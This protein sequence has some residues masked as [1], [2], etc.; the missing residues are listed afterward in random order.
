MLAFPQSDRYR[1]FQ[2]FASREVM[3]AAEQWDREQK[4]PSAVIAA[5]ADRGYLGCCVPGEYGGQGLDTVTFGALNEAIGRGSSA[6]TGVLTV[7]A[8]VSMTLLKWGTAEQKRRWL[9]ALCRGEVLGAFALTEPDAGSALRALGTRFTAEGEGAPLRLSGTKRWISCAQFAGFLLVFGNLDQRSVACI[10]P[11]ESRGVR[12]EPITDLTGFRAAGLAQIR[13]DDV[14][15]PLENVV[16]KPGFGLSH[17]APVGLHYGRIS[18]ACSASG[19]LRGCL[20][21]SVAYCATRKI[22]NKTVGELG[23]I[24]TLI[25]RMGTDLE[26]ASALCYNACRADDE[27]LPE[28]YEKTLMAKYFASRAVVRAASDAVQIQGA[29]GC[30]ASSPVSRYYR[31]AKIMEIIEG[32]TQVHEKMLGDILVGRAAGAVN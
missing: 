32:T 8:M 29:S 21:A 2:A 26:A 7:Q 9:P 13:F 27:R 1:E 15:V 22:G 11:I 10:V 12:V 17:V 31:D 18:T 5:M 25:A 6:L 4:L 19:L 30:H 20:E 3:P 23:M 14:E 16:G 24:K 28:A